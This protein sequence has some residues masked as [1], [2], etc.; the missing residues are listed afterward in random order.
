[1]LF[2]V[3]FIQVKIGDL[4]SYS[5]WDEIC[6]KQLILQIEDVLRFLNENRSNLFNQKSYYST[7]KKSNSEKIEKD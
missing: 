2:I 5:L 1:L 3:F 4:L 7:V 6:T